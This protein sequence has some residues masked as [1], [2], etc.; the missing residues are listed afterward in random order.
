MTDKQNHNSFRCSFDIT[1]LFTNVPLV[2]TIEIVIKNV[3]SR[4]KKLMGSVST[5]DFRDLLN[6]TTMGTVFC[7]NGKYYTVLIIP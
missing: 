5:S 4:K 7:F 1:S 6:L 3:F 2:E